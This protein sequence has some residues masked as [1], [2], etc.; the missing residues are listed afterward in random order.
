M[1]RLVDFLQ[2]IGI[3][4]F[5]RNPQSEMAPSRCRQHVGEGEVLLVAVPRWRFCNQILGR[6]ELSHEPKNYEGIGPVCKHG[7]TNNGLLSSTLRFSRAQE[8]F[9]LSIGNLNAPARAIPLN[10]LF[11]RSRHVSVEEYRVRIFPARITAKHYREWILAG[12]MIP[13]S[14]ELMDHQSDPFSIA[15]NL[16]FRPAQ[17]GVFKHGCRSRQ[18]MTFLARPTGPSFG[19]RDDKS[20]Q[21][22]VFPQPSCNMNIL[23]PSFQDRLAAVSKI[24]NDPHTLPRFEPR[25]G[26]IDKLQT[27]FGLLLVRQILGFDFGFGRPPKLCS[28]RQTEHSVTD[29]RES[30]RQTDDYETD[31]VALL[32]GLLWG[33]PVV[34]PTGPADLSPAMLV[35]GVVEDHE[36]LNSFGNQGFHQD[37]EQAI[38]YQVNAPLPLS[39]EPVDGGEMPRFVKLHRKN[40]L[41]DGVFPYSEDPADDKRHEDAKTRSTEANLETKLVNPKWIW[42]VSFHFGVPP[43]HL[44]LPETGYARNAL[45][46]KQNMSRPP[47]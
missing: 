36:D 45:L 43:P 24:G 31:S 17:T 35:Q 15:E 7:C 21:S 40:D 9:G 26:Q 3:A 23:G 39:Q 27:N 19:R 18:S 6:R 20:V 34:L 11:S 33:R 32:L 4:G 2:L 14:S 5:R 8:L 13:E 47:C 30:Y 10:N 29:S 46:F 22:R 38:G 16:D 41:A 42:Y 1:A 28:I 44:F 25:M 12:A 37:S